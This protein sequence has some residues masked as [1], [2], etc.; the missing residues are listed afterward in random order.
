MKYSGVEEFVLLNLKDAL[1]KVPTNLKNGVIIFLYANYPDDR[2]AKYQGAG[3]LGRMRLVSGRYII[4][5]FP[6]A[7]QSPQHVVYT[8]GHEFGEVAFAVGKE[9]GTLDDYSKQLKDFDKE[10]WV[11]KKAT[12]WG[13]QKPRL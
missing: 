11:D 10:V 2:S 5:I 12:S 8:L 9:A 1:E 3:A 7:Y 13:F 4:E 6:N